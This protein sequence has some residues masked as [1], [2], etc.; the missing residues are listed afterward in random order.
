M[1]NT[2]GNPVKGEDFF[3]DCQ[4]HVDDLREKLRSKAHLLITGPRRSGKTS[5]ISEFRMQEGKE[6]EFDCINLVVQGE[7][8]AV[9]FY[10]HC[11]IRPA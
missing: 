5:L 3:E 11:I 8:S 7:T 2:T 10:R 4:I 9:D 1:K 6:A